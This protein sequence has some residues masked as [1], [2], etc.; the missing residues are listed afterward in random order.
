I[1][2]NL[3]LSESIKNQY[4]LTILKKY[5]ILYC[6]SGELHQFIY[7]NKLKCDRCR[8]C[9]LINVDN[10]SNYELFELEKKLINMKN[11]EV[12]EQINKIKIKKQ[13]TLK[14]EN[15]I[16]KFLSLLKKEYL[17][18]ANNFLFIDKLIEKMEKVIG[19]KVNINN[20]N[21]YLRYDCYIIDH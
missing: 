12:Q 17:S 9:N 13:N 5:A 11:L 14:K 19:K 21:L 1:T 10:M 18:E 16:D 3:N 8:K 7:D 2:L 15:K 20:E 6:K 4:K